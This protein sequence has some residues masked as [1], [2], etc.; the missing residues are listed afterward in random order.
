MNP[1]VRVWA[2]GTA[3]AVTLLGLDVAVGAAVRTL[4]RRVFAPGPA[5]LDEVVV[6][7][8]AAAALALGVWLTASSTAAVLAHAPGRLGAAAEQVAAAWAPLL[9]RR[10]AAALVG[11]SVAGALGPTTTVAREAAPFPGFSASAPAAPVAPAASVSTALPSPPPAVP[12]AGWVPTRPTQR[13]V[14][15]PSLVTSGASG[16]LS[17]SSTDRTGVVI[18]RG[19]TLWAVVAAHLGPDATDAEVAA[20]WPRWYAANRRVIGAD[21]D[22]LLPGQVLEVPAAEVSR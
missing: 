5:S 4:A 22:L 8:A 3:T 11:A 14:P 6:L 13:P 20:Q 1:R 18:H 10:V 2:T 16:A 9:T 15:S 17:S 7:L 19:D 21:P 12:P